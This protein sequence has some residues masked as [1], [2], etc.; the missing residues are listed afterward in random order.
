M[1]WVAILAVALL[2]AAGPLPRTPGWTGRCGRRRPSCAV[3]M[4]RRP[5]GIRASG[6][7]LA[8]VPGQPV[9]AAGAATVVFAGVLAGDRWCHWPT[10]VVCTP[11][12]SRCRP[13]C[14]SVSGW[15]RQ[16]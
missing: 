8:G 1:R 16:R 13:P 4:R 5:I 14:M 15:P 10:R 11:A 12:T 2:C 3:S 6:V 7:D 9:Y